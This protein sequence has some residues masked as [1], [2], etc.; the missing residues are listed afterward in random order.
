MSH[1]CLVH[2]LQS[3]FSDR[4]MAPTAVSENNLYLK[5]RP[6]SNLGYLIS[7]VC[8]CLNM[9]SDPVNFNTC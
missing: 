8:L 2:L 5:D 9:C 7:P 1:D 4:R 3:E 6:T